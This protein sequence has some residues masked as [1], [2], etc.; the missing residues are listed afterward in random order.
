MYDP[1]N[2][3]VERPWFSDVVVVAAAGN[4]GV[5]GLPSGMLFAPA[6]IPS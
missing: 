1:L 4:Y 2:K 6:T 3:A 5:D